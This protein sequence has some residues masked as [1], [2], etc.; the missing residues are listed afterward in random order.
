MESLNLRAIRTLKNVFDVPVGLSDHSRDPLIGPMSSVAVGG[1][2]IEKHFTLSNQMPGPDHVFSLEPEELRIMIESVRKVE[3]A[4]GTGEKETHPVEA[5]LRQF[6]RRS[7]FATEDI[8]PGVLLSRENMAVLRCGVLSPGLD[9]K[10]YE[11]ALGK[12]TVRRIGM[13][14]AIQK[15]DY[16]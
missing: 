4:L 7:I 16:A 13:G 12:T 9:P 1:N 8:N 5:E 2:L 11:T 3:S 14:S 10:F 15:E 6:A